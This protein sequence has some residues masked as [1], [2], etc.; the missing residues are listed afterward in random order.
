MSNQ[1]WLTFDMVSGPK[2]NSLATFCQS[3]KK[4]TYLFSLV[5]NY[6]PKKKSGIHNYCLSVEELLQLKKTQL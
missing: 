6:F 4:K 2:Q 5:D 3:N 1:C